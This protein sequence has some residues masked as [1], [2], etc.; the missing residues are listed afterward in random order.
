MK[1]K[2]KVISWITG[3]CQSEFKSFKVV[4]K[5]LCTVTLISWILLLVIPSYLRF[6]CFKMMVN[7]IFW[8]HFVLHFYYNKHFRKT[9]DAR[10]YQD[11]IVLHVRWWW[12]QYFHFILNYILHYILYYISVITVPLQAWGPSCFNF[13]IW[14]VKL[15]GES[16]WDVVQPCLQW[17]VTVSYVTSALVNC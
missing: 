13:S 11:F 12:I 14:Y 3:I 4:N 8:F 1:N 16:N 9:W 7:L 6:N 15:R 2:V 17:L 5:C 10:F